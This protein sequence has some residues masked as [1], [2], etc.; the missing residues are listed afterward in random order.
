M[1][2]RGGTVGGSKYFASK[3][4][5]RLFADFALK[6]ITVYGEYFHERKRIIDM[7]SSSAAPKC[8]SREIPFQP[9]DR[10]KEDL[11][12]TILQAD[13]AAATI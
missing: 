1:G 13:I 6:F 4:P 11:A 9:L 10:V 2:P 8:C 12:C 3:H 5:W 7:K